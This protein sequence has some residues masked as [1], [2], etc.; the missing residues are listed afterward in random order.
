MPRPSLLSPCALT[1]SP[2][3]LTPLPGFCTL[4]ASNKSAS[5]GRPQRPSRKGLG[6]KAI[7][8][9]PIRKGVPTEPG[10]S[11]KSGARLYCPNRAES[12]FRA[13]LCDRLPGLQQ[14]GGWELRRDY[15]TMRSLSCI[16]GWG[17]TG[18]VL[19][20]QQRDSVG[21]RQLGGTHGN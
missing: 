14:E 11:G 12:P 3:K 5:V 6:K 13:L 15:L 2:L 4:G 20:G 1:H 10:P 21:W 18:R 16:S 17:G 8:R 9:I 7:D 19:Q